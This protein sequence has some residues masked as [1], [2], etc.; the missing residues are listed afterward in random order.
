MRVV[1]GAQ[2][3]LVED[4]QDAEALTEVGAEYASEEAGEH[5]A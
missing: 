3:L 1:E 5:C 2:E 4:L